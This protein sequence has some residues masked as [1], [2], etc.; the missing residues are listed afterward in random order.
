MKEPRVT[1]LRSIEYN[2]PDL[3]KTSRFYEQCWGLK[4]ISEIGSK[5]F[6]RASGSE[7]HIVVI[8]QGEKANVKTINFAA[9]D[10]KMVN[11]LHNKLKGLG[12]KIDADPAVIEK[13]GGGYGFGFTDRDGIHYGI[14]SDVSTHSDASMESDRPF[15][16]SH[17]VLNS[18][19]VEDQTKF[20][21]DILGFRVSDRTERMNFIRCSSDHHSV[22]FAHSEGP[23]LNHAAFELPNF[24]ALMCGS[25]R[26]K[27]KG[28]PVQWGV[29]RHGPGN[30]VFGYFFEPN[31]MVVEY[32]AEVEQVDDN[33][34]KTGTPEE[35]AQ[36]VKGPDRWGFADPPSPLLRQ[37]M[38]GNPQAPNLENF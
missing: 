29:G 28:F 25:G 12:I 37:C 38:G 5:H 20:F 14:S 32:T 9:P 2:V 13:P 35:W 18:T 30:N 27:Q 19:K 11:A 17:V 21:R 1:G 15:K 4:K 6:F 31:G 33:T 10:K 23:S 22:A 8:H 34:Y 26:M 16:L 7:H 3:S 24:D 36:R